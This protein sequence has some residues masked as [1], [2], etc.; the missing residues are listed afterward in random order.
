MRLTRLLAVLALAFNCTALVAASK[1]H[2]AYT[3]PEHADADFAVQGEYR[4]E[5][6]SEGKKDIWGAQVIALGSGKFHAVGYKG[7]LPGDG[8]NEKDKKQADGQT[9]GDATRFQTEHHHLAIRDGVMTVS[10]SGGER[11]GELKKVHRQSPMLGAKPPAGAVVL[12]GGS[13]VEHF[14]G[15]RMTEDGLL[16]QGAKSKETF[17]S[18]TC[19]LEFRL[20]YMPTARDQGRGNSGLY[21]QGRYEV[22]M[23]DSFG[24]E[25]QD[26]EC[27]GL[28]KIAAPRI[29]MCYPPLAWQTYDVDYT[30]AVFQD[31][32]KVKNARATVRHNGVVIH[33]HAELTHIVGGNVLDEG[34]E[35][36]PIFLQ[37]HGNPVRYRNI[38]VVHK[39]AP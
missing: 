20:P 15:G 34:P 14:P 7:G 39:Q 25:G 13:S 5:V 31:D 30:A 3:D 2:P 29:N 21:L 12:L 26:N 4:G 27:G 8:W 38:W 23:L 35:P 22:Q 6:R 17:G 28:Y 36:G 10:D 24:L 19:H 33:D 1:D 9:E 11:V 32:K 16:M 37:N 18:F